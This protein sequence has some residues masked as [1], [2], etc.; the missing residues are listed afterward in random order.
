M[1]KRQGVQIN[2]LL[3]MIYSQGYEAQHVVDWARNYQRE[4]YPM[5]KSYERAINE[6]IGGQ[7]EL[8][9]AMQRMSALIQA[10][11]DTSIDKYEAA[12]AQ[13]IEHGDGSGIEALA[14]M[15]ARDSV[16]LARRN[17]ELPDGAIT[18]ANVEAALGV[19]MAGQFVQAAASETASAPA[20]VAAPAQQGR[21]APLVSRDKPAPQRFAFRPQAQQPQQEDPF[22]N[23]AQVG[24]QPYCPGQARMD[25]TFSQASLGPSR[26]ILEGHV[27]GTEI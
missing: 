20:P 22:N 10:S 15:M 26:T 19:P 25:A 9:K 27:L 17:G 24:G 11:D 16:E 1:T 7:P 5:A 13:Y 8:G 2:A 23:G 18:A 21:S 14:P 6:F 3:S 12:L 4:G